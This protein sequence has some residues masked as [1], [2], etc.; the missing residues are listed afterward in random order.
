MRYWS[1]D[2]RKPSAAGNMARRARDSRRGTSTQRKG[3]GGT[4]GPVTPF[5]RRLYRHGAV[6]SG[7]VQRILLLLVTAGLIYAFVLGDSGAIRIMMLRSERA[8]L[9]RQVAELQANAERLRSEIARLESDPFY[10]EKVG[11]ERFGYVK[12]DEKVYRIVTEQD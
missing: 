5:L 6:T 1:G 11:R 3:S 9:E 2:K 10:I 8:D 7:P 4:G 12:P